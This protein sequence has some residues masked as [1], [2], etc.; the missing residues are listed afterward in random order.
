MTSLYA[1]D[2]DTATPRNVDLSQVT[3]EL[4]NDH[5]E[6]ID[7]LCKMWHDVSGKK[8]FPDFSAIKDTYTNDVLKPQM[9]SDE[10]PLALIAFLHGEPIGLCALRPTCI[11]KV[12]AVPWSDEHPEKKPWFAIFVAAACQKQGVGKLLLR[13]TMR[14]AQTKFGFDRA[15]VVPDD[16]ELE[17]LYIK[18]G[19]TKI[20]DTTLRDK[21]APVL[22]IEFKK[23]LSA[24]QP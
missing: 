18:K 3:I 24:Q 12:G 22:E 2:I 13:E 15:Y 14:Y 1:A 5:P 16:A 21:P 11:P 23:L 6:L 9:H 19:C 10:L 17:A 20:A 8:A 7:T 4:Q